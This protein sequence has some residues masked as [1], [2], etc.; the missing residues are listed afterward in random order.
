V[1]R[2]QP[3]TKRLKF[4][5]KDLI[6]W[7]HYKLQDFYKTLINLKKKNTALWNG[8]AGGQ[9]TKVSTN[10]DQAIYAFT[11][12]RGPYKLFAI[13]NLSAHKKDVTF[14]TRNFFG[15]YYDA[16]SGKLVSFSEGSKLTMKPWEYLVLERK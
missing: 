7:D 12:I 5:D 16:F 6:T 2:N 8:A 10:D 14:L 3:S 1:A 4:F 13:F 11:R 9:M 15:S